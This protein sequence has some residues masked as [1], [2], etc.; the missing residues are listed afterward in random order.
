MNVIDILRGVNMQE[1][2][3]NWDR[4]AEAY[5]EFTSGDQSYSYAI[6]WPCIKEM[7]PAL[8]GKR[9]IDL[10]CGTGRFTFLLEGEKP[11]E[12]L[13]VDLSDNMLQ[14]AKKKAIKN[15]SAARF[16]K[17]DA[18]NAFTDEKFDLV[19][20]STLTHYVP[21]LD[22][23]FINV[24]R[25]LLPEGQCVFSVMN[26]VYTAQYPIKSGDTFPDDSEWTVRYLD[27]RERG[28][29]QPWIEYND[30]VDNFMSYSYHYT[31]SDYFNVLIRAGLCLEE[32]QEPL[33]PDNWKE[34]WP[35]R[36]NS[37]IETPSYMIFRAKK[38]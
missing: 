28:Y 9:I 16:I 25:M 24:S 32:V 30:T 37:F 6:E 36:Y 10:G 2:E 15:G 8:T 31:F 27:K 34:K 19:F 22:A 20:S 18:S 4:M 7:L 11:A 5:E 23:F 21:D 29:I 17:A 35:D 3:L 12:I 1:T 33:P 26:P 14:L 13:G 38:V